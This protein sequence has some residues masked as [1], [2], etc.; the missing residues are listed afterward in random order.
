MNYWER[1]LRLWEYAYFTE[2]IL[3]VVIFFAIVVGIRNYKTGKVYKY[4]F[5]YSVVA[6]LVFASV[7]A[8]WF[9][10]LKGSNYFPFSILMNMI[11]SITEVVCFYLFFLSIINSKAK[12][13]L[14]KYMVSGF[15][16][17]AFFLIYKIVRIGHTNE[18]A[19]RILD[20]MIGTQM[21]LLLIPCL[22]YFYQ[23]ITAIAKPTDNMIRIVRGVLIYAAINAS[24]NLILVYIKNNVRE[25]ARVFV[26]LSYLSLCYLFIEIARLLRIKKTPNTAFKRI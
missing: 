5:I 2:P 20:F 7:D 19:L 9:F 10:G 1:L 23:L 8:I 3:E 15:L 18:D 17:M 21:V 13:N 16:L 25:L 24:F 6:L 22:L 12:K 14:L 26:T 4:L 11:Y